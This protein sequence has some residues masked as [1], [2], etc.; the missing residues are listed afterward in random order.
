MIIR[1]GAAGDEEA[2]PAANLTTFRDGR[3]VEMVHHPD[4]E[5]ALAA[6]GIPGGQSS[7]S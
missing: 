4:P 5:A 3:A 1:P 2:S 7:R 6:A